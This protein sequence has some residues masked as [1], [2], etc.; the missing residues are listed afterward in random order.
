MTANS[1]DRRRRHH[2]PCQQVPGFCID[3]GTEP[4][5]LCGYVYPDHCRGGH[6]ILPAEVGG[7]LRRLAAEGVSFAKIAA[8][9][10]LT[11]HTVRRVVH[12]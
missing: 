7:K 11:V 10:G 6:P 1:T 4:H 8:E 12:G 2:E 3:P 9:L 5:C